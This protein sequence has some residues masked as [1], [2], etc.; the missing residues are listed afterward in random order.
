MSDIVT[1]PADAREGARPAAGGAA[2][3]WSVPAFY[4]YA[5]VLLIAGLL[6]AFWYSPTATS[7]G[8]FAQKIFYYH[9]PV[10]S[11]A[12]YGF[13]VAFVAAVLYL[14]HPDAKYDRYGVVGVRLGLLFSL[15]VMA[16]GMIWGRLAWNTWWN[17]EPRLTT[18]LIACLLYAG[19]F[20]LRAT[21]E[22]E[23]RRATYAAVF[24]IIAFIDVPIT[25]FSTRLVPVNAQLHPV[26]D[27]MGANV[28]IP[29]GISMLGMALLFVAFLRQGVAIEAAREDLEAVKARLGS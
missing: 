19:Y 15:L 16:T 13:G 10:A 2:R 8:G 6:L 23:S 3:L 1:A 14:R 22:D 27:T 12:L 11:A 4:I 29:F 17:W 28:A 18:Y 9:V 5:G 25:Y 21:V 26:V 7:M 20:V 24:A